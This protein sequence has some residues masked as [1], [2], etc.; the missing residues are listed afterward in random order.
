MYSTLTLIMPIL[1]WPTSIVIAVWVIGRTQSNGWLATRAGEY[2][3][4]IGVLA[5]MGAMMAWLGGGAIGS[6]WLSS[7]FGLPLSWTLDEF[8]IAYFIGAVMAF[9]VAMKYRKQE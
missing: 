7:A 4:L 8:N 2:Q 5:G 9:G 1:T 3:P 6:K